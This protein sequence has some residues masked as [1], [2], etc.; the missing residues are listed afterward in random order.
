MQELMLGWQ[1]FILSLGRIGSMVMLVPI[2]GGTMVP[3]AVKIMITLILGVACFHLQPY[4]ATLPALSLVTFCLLLS[5]E[6]ILGMIFSLVFSLL[7]AACQM[8]G[9]YMGFQMM[10]SSGRTNLPLSRQPTTITGGFVYL[11][12]LLLFVAIDGHHVLIRALIYS[13]SVLP[14]FTMPNNLG[15]VP[16]WIEITGRMF[17]IALRLSLPVV[18]VLILTNLVLGIIARTMPQVNVF[19]IGLPIQLLAGILSMMLIVTSLT[20]AELGLFRDW[21]KEIFGLIRFFAR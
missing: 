1:L 16:L 9:E 12:A 11:F 18:A 13:F 17:E 2:I 14:V 6:I 5:K 21:A 8:A 4:P 19:V 7:L 15:T 20:A 3:N 10:F